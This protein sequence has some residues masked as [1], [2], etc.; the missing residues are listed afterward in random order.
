MIL[1]KGKKVLPEQKKNVNMRNKMQS[2]KETVVFSRKDRPEKRRNEKKMKRGDEVLYKKKK[3][4]KLK[5]S[6]VEK[7]KEEINIL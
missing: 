7:R 5:M 2:R 4:F 6:D 3:N 1:V